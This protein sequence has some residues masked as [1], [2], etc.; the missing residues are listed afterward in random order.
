[1]PRTAR[2]KSK[3]GIYHIMLRGIDR[4]YIFLDDSDREKFL[5]YLF[6]AKEISEF[7]LYAYCLMG[8]H[9]H[10]LMRENGE[11]GD[12]VKRIAVGYVQWFNNRHGRTGHL[13]QNRYRSEAIESERYL[14]A[15]A[16]YIHQNPVKAKMVKKAGDYE[17]SSYK[18]YIDFYKGKSTSIDPGLIAA[19]FSTQESFEEFMNK[20]NDDKFLDYEVKQKYTDKDLLSRINGIVDINSLAR[21]PKN[22]RD[23]IILEIYNMTGASMRQLSR[24][25]GIGRSIIEN[26]VRNSEL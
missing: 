6:R 26:A 10:L 15:A 3:T 19:Y 14:V 11:L 2:E 4:R 8:N 25:M 9:V 20:P 13:F 7:E 21:L 22:E 18:D 17:W 23:K 5:Y 16:R 24:V 12:N 1:M